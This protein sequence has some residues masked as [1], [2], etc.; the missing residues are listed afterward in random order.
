MFVWG[1]PPGGTGISQSQ[2]AGVSKP[3]FAVRDDDAGELFSVLM[4]CYT[5]LGYGKKKVGLRDAII[6]Q[7]PAS[8]LRSAAFQRLALMAMDGGDEE[9]AWQA[10]QK[11]MA[12]NPHDVSHSFLEVQLHMAAGQLEQAGQR[13]DFWYRKLCKQGVGEDEDIM[14]LLGRLRD[15]PLAAQTGLECSAMDDAGLEL[16]QWLAAVASRPPRPYD[17]KAE[18]MPDFD[19]HGTGIAPDAIPSLLL[20]PASLQKVEDEW[21]QVCSLEKP[22]GTQFAVNADGGELWQQEVEL[23]QFLQDHPEA[24]DSLSI[25]DDLLA[26]VEMH[27]MF[28]APGLVRSLFLPLLERA[29]AILDA[30]VQAADDGRV[31]P[32]L[33]DENRDGLRSLV[34][35]VLYWE[36]NREVLRFQASAEKLLALNPHDNHG[37]RGLLINVLLAA[38]QDEKA[39]Q[40]SDNFPQD[41]LADVA[42][43]RVLALF[44]LGRK[45]E[46]GVALAAALERMPKVPRYLYQKRIAQPELSPY[47]ISIGGDDQAWEYREEMRDVWLDSD[48][49]LAW[50]KRQ[51]KKI[52][53]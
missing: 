12:D 16:G 37:I 21:S 51:E 26:V 14:R 18:E 29:E 47:G 9:Q 30:T 11:A 22:F 34:R 31:L 1:P 50:L 23:C 52:R 8:P 42:Y 46:A 4:E 13:A 2:Q 49:A 32:W 27:P 43:G 39:L 15:D 25:L 53:N 10:F 28:P 40:L 35:Q 6:E 20:T 17:L 33:F 41:M 48:G 7:C 3:P 5:S 24:F 36:E 44:R 38:G 19:G 45:A